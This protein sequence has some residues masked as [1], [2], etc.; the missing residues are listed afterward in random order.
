M[1]YE[2]EAEPWLSLSEVLI[3]VFPKVEGKVRSGSGLERG[4]KAGYRT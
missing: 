1:A 2:V 4:V 3:F